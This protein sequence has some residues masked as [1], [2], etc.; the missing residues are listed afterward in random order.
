MRGLT[1]DLLEPM[2]RTARMIEGHL[3]GLNSLFS[4]VKRRAS[5]YRAVEHDGHALL[6][7]RETHPLVLLTH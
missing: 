3:E 4:A 2:A 7:R 5:G 1:G 6:R